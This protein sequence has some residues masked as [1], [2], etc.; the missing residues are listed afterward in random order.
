MSM[1]AIFV[2]V[3]AAELSRLQV[4]PSLAE[5]LFQD[6][7]LIPPV[8]MELSKKMQDRVRASGP[9]MVAGALSRLDP[10]IRKQVEERLGLTA[11]SM[12]AGS[13]GEE[14]LKMMQERAAR[15]SGQ[16][17]LTG[18][19]AGLSLDKHLHGGD[20]LHGWEG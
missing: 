15:P 18:D 4:N 7:P 10:R 19:G 2:Q 8:F 17:P 16:K 1:N 5:A 20:Y 14:V 9:Q 12:A 6:G 11:A 13:G 3:N